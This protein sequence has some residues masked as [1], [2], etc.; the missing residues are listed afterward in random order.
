MQRLVLTAAGLLWLAGAAHGQDAASVP[1]P[2]TVAPQKKA[3]QS[4]E[5]GFRWDDHPS[6]RLGRGTR[7]DFRFRLQADVK[8][9]DAPLP[10]D[11]DAEA[12]T[13][14]IARRRIG[15]EGEI[16][17]LFDY[18]VDRELAV[19]E[20][21][22]AWRDVYIN[23]KQFGFAEV[24]AGKFKVPFSL[25]ENTSS[26]NL[27][28]VYRSRAAELLAPG[29]DRGVMAHGRVLD[30]GIL[31][32]EAGLFEHDGSN[33]RRRTSNDRV[34]GDRT[35]A[36]RV[37][38]QPFRS[39]TSPLSD[40]AF[41]IA[42]T[43]SHIDEGFPDLRGRTALDVNFYRPDV[44]VNG[45]RRRT[46][47]E[48]RWRPGPYSIKA[49]YMKLTDERLGQSVEDTDLSRLFA[50][51][52]YVSG[53]W[54]IT[55][56]NKADG[57][58]RPRRPL[59]LKD[60]GFGAVEVAARIERIEFGSDANGDVPSQGP[61]ADVIA[62]NADRVETVGVNWYPNRWLK[63]QFNVIRETIA[64][65]ERGPLPGQPTFWSRVLRFQFAM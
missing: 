39:M 9:S 21:E 14:D 23:Y 22:E 16:V 2:Q 32:Y 59:L 47:L 56:E 48:F 13:V 61:R 30:R 63:I 5:W 8:D 15:V 62:G 43:S 53:T 55:G 20:G 25:D 24:Q 35:T 38:L 11:D 50:T 37:T 1:S 7:I 65:P 45:T 44:W 41:G 6:L 36:G 17:N 57:V 19:D 52:W 29:R 27:D 4:E 58:D 28:L 64:D 10:E 51:G 3:P 26:T 46:G 31:R 42:F 12:S 33:A 34:H 60:S 18:E 40:L 49:E 54:A